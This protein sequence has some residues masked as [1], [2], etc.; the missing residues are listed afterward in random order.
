MTAFVVGGPFDVPITKLKSGAFVVEESKLSE[1]AEL[2]QSF[3][4]TGG[5]Y[6]FSRKSSRGSTPVYVGMTKKQRLIDEAFN[7]RNRNIV[8]KWL[9]DQSHRRLQ[10]WTIVPASNRSKL[11]RDAGDAI[12]EIEA[13]LIHTAANENPDLLN[14][15]K[16]GGQKWT[17]KGV[18]KGGRGNRPREAK[19]FRKLIGLD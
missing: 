5:V 2:D 3:A 4:R 13:F 9:N 7:H 19:D 6:V 14:L 8:M 16:K 12:D 15:R 1:L 11:S 17:I 18:D 10:I